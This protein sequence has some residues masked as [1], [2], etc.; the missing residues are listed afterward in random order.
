M[1]EILISD[2]TISYNNIEGLKKTL[3]SLI[4]QQIRSEE[5]SI[6][7]EVIVIDGGSNDGTK[8]LLQAYESKFAEKGIMYKYLSEPDE[9][10][11][12][13]MN[14]GIDMATGQW[15]MFLNSGDVMYSFSTLNDFWK[16]AHSEGLLQCDIIYGD[17]NRE[18][19]DLKKDRTVEK[20]MEPLP[21]ETIVHGLPFSHQ[22]VF[23]KTVLFKTRKYDETF[24]ISGD[25]EWFLNAYQEGKIFVYI[26]VCVSSFDTQGISAM[27]LYENYLEAERIRFMHGISETVVLRRV[28]QGIWWFL[29][30][31][32]VRSEIVELINRLIRNK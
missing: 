32:R 13:A 12:S 29:D 23:T 21:L 11:Y 10:V 9:G 2:I 5:I 3:N 18:Y 27:N 19:I 22:S 31:L 4:I 20:V 30:K 26:P 16:K 15:I 24:R 8:N 7:L 1:E 6:G 14:K 25:Y 17:S 28:K